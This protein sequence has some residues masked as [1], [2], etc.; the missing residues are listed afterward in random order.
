M[1]VLL[2]G[3]TG[4]I[5]GAL[6]R[7]LLAQGH[8]LVCAVREPARLV[9]PGTRWRALQADLAQVPSSD[10]WQPHLAGIDAVVN[11]VGILRQQPGQSFQALHTDGPVALFQACADAGVPCV[12]QISALGAN[13]QARSGYHRS[14]K[15]ADDVL[16][17]LPLAG[18]VVQPSLVFSPEGPSARLFL[19]LAVAPALLMPQRGGMAVQPV[20]LDDVV[21]GVLAVLHAPPRPVATLAFAGPQPLAM[22]D[23]LAGLRRALGYRIPQWLLGLPGVL[24]KAGAAVAGRVPGSFLDA[25]TAGMLLRGNTAPAQ[26]LQCLL[27]RPARAVEGFI[28][29]AQAAGLRRDAVLSLWLPVLRVALAALWIW[30]GIVSLGLFPVEES[31]ALLAQ[32]GLRGPMAANALYGAAVL[33]IA[34]GLLTLMSPRRWRAAVWAGQLL[35]IAGYTVLISIFLPE[36]WLHPYGP[37]S[38]NLPIL[39]AIGLLWALE[40]ARPGGK[41]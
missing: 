24:F 15:A 8:E 20:H 16:R 34:L 6:A 7:A 26:D 3:A 27:G 14:K 36:F 19:T 32:V 39:A 12:V 13:E 33:D 4:L 30:T 17:S 1:R 9:L 41:G 31:Y 10:W 18:A 38:K 37:I 11:A 40:P 35:L 23:Y 29:P 28:K 22:R 25:D 2:T 5:G 21:A